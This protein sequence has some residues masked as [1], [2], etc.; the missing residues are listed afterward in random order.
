MGKA[1]PVAMR[2]LSSNQQL[3]GAKKAKTATEIIFLEPTNSL[4]TP[5]HKHSHSQQTT[6]DKRQDADN[7]LGSS[8]SFK[9]YYNPSCAAHSNRHPQRRYDVRY[10]I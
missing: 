3:A 1:N 4:K 6:T 9:G 2:V 10:P 8:N 5:E 7:T